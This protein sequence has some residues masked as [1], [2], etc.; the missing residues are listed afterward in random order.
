MI[1]MDGKVVAAAAV[2]AGEKAEIEMAYA[3][4]AIVTHAAGTDKKVMILPG[5]FDGATFVHVGWPE[6]V[7][8]AYIGASGGLE[9]D[10]PA[11]ATA[12]QVLVGG[13]RT[14][15]IDLPGAEPSQPALPY[16]PVPQLS[17]RDPRWASH[18]LGQATGHTKKIGSWGCLTVAY[19]SLAQHWQ[20]TTAQPD[21]FNN[22]LVRAGA[23]KAQFIQPGALATR[24]PLA[25]KY[26]GYKKRE[27][28]TMHTMIGQ[29]LEMGWPVPCRVDFNPKD[30][31]FDQHWVLVCGLAGSGDYYM[32]DPQHGDYELVSKRYGIAG[33]DILEALFY[34]PK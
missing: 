17:Q 12:V 2:A 7:A 15:V 11:E 27:D 26:H 18:R 6:D 3:V 10:L 34:S 33:S 4:G 22:E 30:T 31:D 32:M 28:P 23:F 29:W 19:C 24:Y 9:I 8:V 20:I 5:K 13:L 16:I 1:G 14:A 25:V 21:V